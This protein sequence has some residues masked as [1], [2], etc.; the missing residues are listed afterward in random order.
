MIDFRYHLVSLVSV[1]LALAIGVVLG[2]GP[3]RDTIG[4][5]LEDQVQALRQDKGNLQEAVTNRDALLERRESFVEAVAPALVRGRLA[6]A[7]VAVVGL[8]GVEDD[9]LAAVA[10][11]LAGAGA[12]VT[13]V[14]AVRPSWSDPASAEVREEVVRATAVPAG[15]PEVPTGAA[16]PVAG[17][18]AALL[19]TA[20]LDLPGPEPAAPEGSP[21]PPGSPAAVREALAAA[22]LAEVR[23]PEDGSTVLATSV[24]VVAPP[25]PVLDAG[26][27]AA[28][29]AD[30]EQ[31]RWLPLLAALREPASAGL[32]TGPVSAGE[33][34]GLLAA[35]RTA[36]EDGAVAALS[37]VDGV[38][39]PTGRVTAVL[40]LAEQLAGGAGSYG[41][42]S[43]AAAA[44]PPPGGPA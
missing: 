13:A 24:V 11:G 22:G 8:P 41:A 36:Q 6:G 31:A 18:L 9:D 4:A 5:T 10:E 12:A 34:P 44:A 19:A 20:L 40:A 21:P 38:E 43:T 28:D 2:A 27:S 37:T 26:A 7:E 33:P 3:L 16:D 25:A 14:A 1:F 39:G 29:G 32:L 35:V 30:A 17:G 15:A 42:S 23:P